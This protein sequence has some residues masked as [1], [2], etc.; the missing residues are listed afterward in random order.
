M[1]IYTTFCQKNCG[2]ATGKFSSQLFFGAKILIQIIYLIFKDSVPL[3]I[4]GI[5][6][7]NQP[8]IFN[9]V[10][11][12]FKPFLR[13][14]LRSRIIFHGTDR[15]SLHKHIAPEHLPQ[16][17][18]GL[19]KEVLISGDEWYR[20]LVKCDKEYLAVNSYGLRKDKKGK[21]RP[22]VKQI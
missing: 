18:G 4:K 11:Q 15:E 14:K 7:I 1:A 16:C 20:L 12:L 2:L 6:I 19:V 17:Y 22:N 13:E 3:R 21:P 8:K 9:I 5:Q 10:F